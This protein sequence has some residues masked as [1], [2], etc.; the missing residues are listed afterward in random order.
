MY[1]MV[2]FKILPAIILQYFEV[3]PYT[4]QQYFSPTKLCKFMFLGPYQ[5]LIGVEIC[6][7][8][9]EVFTSLQISTPIKSW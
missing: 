2:L 9:S 5:E 1:D 3:V 8:S 4:L 6:L 7:D